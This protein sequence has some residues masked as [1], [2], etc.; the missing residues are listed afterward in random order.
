MSARPA[1]IGQVVRFGVVGGLAA[2]LDFGILS[3]IVHFGG[4]RYS[5]RIVSVAVTLVFTWIL[6]RTMTF[7]TAA[8]PTWREFAHYTAV[9]IAGIVLNVAIYWAALGLG[10]PTWAAFVLGTGI[11]AV[12]NFFRYRAVLGPGEVST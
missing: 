8:A 4:S 10:A 3:L 9:A 11:A 7:A 12:F 1:W 2:A 6:N 5:A